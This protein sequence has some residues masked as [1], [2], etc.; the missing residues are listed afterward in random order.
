MRGILAVCAMPCELEDLD[1]FF[2]ASEY[3]AAAVDAIRAALEGIRKP[4]YEADL[5]GHLQRL[6]REDAALAQI[7]IP[8]PVEPPEPGDG[9]SDDACAR[10]IPVH[11]P[12]QLKESVKSCRKR[13][14]HYCH[15]VFWALCRRYLTAQEHAGLLGDDF[16]STHS[17][18]AGANSRH[19]ST[20]NLSW[21]CLDETAF[22]L[23]VDLSNIPAAV[24]PA[25]VGQGSETFQRL[26]ADVHRWQQ[27]RPQK[28][29]D[30]GNIN[31][32]RKEKLWKFKA[33]V[34]DQLCGAAQRMLHAAA[35]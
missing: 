11:R 29:S 1:T 15:L 13:I 3:S 16:S 28:K 32:Q 24:R 30:E 18:G 33:F 23:P 26:V 5:G 27:K 35:E 25:T 6:M 31:M 4:Q 10:R 2:V 34:A 21:Y 9:S 14:A 12:M 17:S 8:S 19:K 22:G 7:A 20:H